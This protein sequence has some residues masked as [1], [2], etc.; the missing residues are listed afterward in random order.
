MA[1]SRWVNVMLKRRRSLGKPTLAQG[2]FTRCDN[3]THSSAKCSSA[4][5]LQYQFAVSKASAAI[6]CPVV[7]SSQSQ[8]SS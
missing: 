8:C 1:R 7:R 4:D 3:V 2:D 6:F 5:N